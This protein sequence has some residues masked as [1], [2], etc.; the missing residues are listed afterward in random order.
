[1]WVWLMGMEVVN[2]GAINGDVVNGGVVNW[3]VVS[4][5]GVIS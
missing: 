5:V 4:G 1:M 2:D 3:G